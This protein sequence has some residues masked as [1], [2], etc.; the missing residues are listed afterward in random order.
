MR[1]KEWKRKSRMIFFKG[2][3]NSNTA[4]QI[5]CLII[6]ILNSSVTRVYVIRT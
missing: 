5:N 4:K 2:E 3:L 1:N 6:T